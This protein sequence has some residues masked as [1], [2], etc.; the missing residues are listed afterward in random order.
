[1]N[2]RDATV[3]PLNGGDHRRERQSG[4]SVLQSWVVAKRR[5]ERDRNAA[6]PKVTLNRSL[7]DRTRGFPV[8]QGRLL[9]AFNVDVWLTEEGWP[10]RLEAKSEANYPSG[11]EFSAELS[12]EIRDVNSED[13]SVEPPTN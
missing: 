4:W 1:M 13:V 3:R 10:A 7:C 2:R 6:A 9:T 8:I 11:R 5:R 12:L